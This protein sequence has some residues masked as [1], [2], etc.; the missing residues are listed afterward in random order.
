MAT[1]RAFYVTQ[2]SL[3]VW[4]DDTEWQAEPL[5]FA[6]NDAGLR[7]FDAYLAESKEHVSFVVIDVIEEEFALERIPKLGLRDRGALMR[8][9]LQR[10]FPRTPYRMPLYQGLESSGD[11][12]SVVVHCAITN[13][14]LL[15]PWLQVMQRHEVPLTGVFS[16]PLMAPQLLAKLHKTTGPVMLI[17][18]HQ[19]EKL[20]QV[21]IHDGHVRSARLSQ[22]PPLSDDAYPQF[23]LTEIGRSRRYLERNRMLSGMQQLDVYIITEAKLAERVLAEAQ[24][25]SP[26]RVHFIKP[27]TA[28]KHVGLKSVPEA[29]CLESLYLAMAAQRRP[30]RS[31][32]VSGESRFWH[33]RR[34]RHAVIGASVA[35]AAVCSVLSGLYFSDAWFLK[36]RAAEIETQLVQ[37]T[38]T[39]R[40]EN[41]RFDPIK[42][43]SHEMK[44][45]VDTGDFILANRLPVPWV[46]QQL[47]L[48]MGNYSD[49][50]IL[51]LGWSAESAAPQNPARPARPGENLPV[52]VP[53]ITAVTADITA[54]ITP[55]DGNMRKAFARIDALVADLQARTAFADVS[56]VEYPLDPRPQSALTGE[57]VKNGTVEAARFRLRL[58]YPLQP[59]AAVEADD[60]S[61]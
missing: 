40:R 2:G 50:Q 16:V 8:R 13:H 31:Y 30:R 12:E 7:A 29:D 46:M 23:V 18:Q 59:S 52:P 3:S 39:F 9:R 1:H 22:S 11:N 20:R 54:D 27:Q 15:D 43:D 55:F 5:T 4:Q 53:A 49:V 17:T 24:S 44:L 45:A 57:I 6:D 51:N 25:D 41:E 26:L 47:G 35:T 56:V 60:G 34:L 28:A 33:M 42:A 21:F 32:A 38:E 14:E 58:R 48:V 10:K 37:L 61:V 19:R 36:S